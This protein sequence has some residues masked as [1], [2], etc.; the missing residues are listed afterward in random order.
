L[1]EVERLAQQA[2][3]L[4]KKYVAKGKDKLSLGL[5]QNDLWTFFC[6]ARLCAVEGDAE[7]CRKWMLKSASKRYL[8]KAKESQLADFGT[9][10]NL[11]WFKE[12]FQKQTAEAA[13]AD[14]EEP[15]P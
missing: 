13:A 2:Q 15:E 1:A 3:D 14:V 6:M 12:M 8:S 9:V 7:E 5:S 11:E 10:A 4:Y